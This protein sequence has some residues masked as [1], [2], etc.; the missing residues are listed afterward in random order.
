MKNSQEEKKMML[1]D[2]DNSDDI[3]DIQR[4]REKKNEPRREVLPDEIR[5]ERL[6]SLKTKMLVHKSV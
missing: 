4:K 1:Y 6:I 2:E 3:S 5:E